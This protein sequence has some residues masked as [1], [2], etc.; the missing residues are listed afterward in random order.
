M[1]ATE[2]RSLKTQF[3]KSNKGLLVVPLV[4]TSRRMS[5]MSCPSHLAGKASEKYRQYKH[6]SKKNC[7]PFPVELEMI[8]LVLIIAPHYN[9]TRNVQRYYE[10][11][12]RVPSI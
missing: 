2:V 1:D 5:R 8:I 7:A 4:S 6:V 3:W 12:I 10:N 9:V 11:V